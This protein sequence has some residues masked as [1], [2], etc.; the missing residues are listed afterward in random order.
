MAK[1]QAFMLFPSTISLPPRTYMR[2]IQ[3]YGIQLIHS[4]FLQNITNATG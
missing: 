2:F 1:M 3:F 4:Q